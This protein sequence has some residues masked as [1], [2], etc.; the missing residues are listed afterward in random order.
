[1]PYLQVPYPASTREMDL[2]VNVREIVRQLQ[3]GSITLNVSKYSG[4][5]HGA[6]VT[7]AV[8]GTGI[9][10]YTS[11]DLLYGS[12]G[13]VLSKLNIGTPGQFLRVLSGL[14]QWATFSAGMIGT[15]L[16]ATLGGTGMSG[17]AVGDMIYASGVSNLSPLTI[18]ANGTL[19]QASG[20]IPTWVVFSGTS[21]IVSLG[22]V[23]SGT[24]NGVVIGAAYGG[25]DQ[26]TVASGD[27]LFGSGGTVWKRLGIGSQGQ[28]IQALGGLP[29]W[30]TFSGS[31]DVRTLGTVTAGIWNGT[32]IGGTYGGTGVNNGASTITIG[33]N[34]IFSGAS[35]FAMSLSGATALTAPTTGKLATLSGAESFTQKTFADAT[36]IGT[37]GTLVGL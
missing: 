5:W 17:Y 29:A 31:T 2:S 7:A 22:T 20:G 15:N 26:S 28:L 9:T 19:L 24:W 11:G 23:T 4:T 14:P 30:V 8:G 21:A 3:D 16:S 12:G 27:L 6:T 18:G 34:I 33:A 13:N 1:M 37:A 32:V 36:T 35:T 25:T 10:A